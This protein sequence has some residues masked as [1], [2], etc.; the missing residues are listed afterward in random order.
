MPAS[1]IAQRWSHVLRVRDKPAYLAI[2][3]AIASDIQNGYLNLDDRLPPIRELSK[4][5]NLDYTTVAR[6]YSEAQ[7]RGLIFSKA[8]SGSFIRTRSIHD[9]VPVPSLIEMTMNMP[10]EP[11]LEH[12]LSQFRRGMKS[13]IER[14]DFQTLMR[15]QDFGGSEE[16]RRAAATWL[17]PLL[18]HINC[19]QILVTP[20]IQPTLSGLFATLVGSG[21]VMCCEEITYPGVKAISAQLGIQ[22]C[23]LPMDKEGVQPDAFEAACRVQEV[24]ALYLNPTIQNPSTLTVPVSR[25]LEL[26]QV[27]RKFGVRII[28]DDAYGMLPVKPIA[29]FA[30]LAPDIVF[31]VSGLAKTVSAG[32]R[33]AYCVSPTVAESRRLASALRATTIMAAPLNVALASHWIT[34]G[35]ANLA[36]AQ[37]RSIGQARQKLAKQYLEGYEFD[38]HPDGFHLW[39]H[40]PEQWLK[41]LFCAELL[42]RGVAVA[43]ADMFCVSKGLENKHHE[44]AVNKMSKHCVRLCLGGPVDDSRMKT[45]L[46]IISEVLGLN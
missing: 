25:R 13:V 14:G 33:V 4:A 28:E 9:A 42:S 21:H 5:L 8:G 38:A 15:Y 7:H 18:P 31:Y 3:D 37:I 11:R 46:Q 12:L 39:L 43:S 44:H 24:K 17:S 41:P 35:T 26:I 16:D 36:L 2:A 32:L 20:G 22:L 34:D 40:L 19:E 1:L 30:S 10:P 23:G 27:A 29:P 45:A 6:A